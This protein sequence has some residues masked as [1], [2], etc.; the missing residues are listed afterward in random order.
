MTILSIGLG[1]MIGA[2]LRYFIS[3]KARGRLSTPFPIG[4]FIVNIIGS[5]VLGFLVALNLP[6]SL[7]LPFAEGFCGALTT[8]STFALEY[9]TLYSK[10]FHTLALIYIFISL[11]CGILFFTLGTLL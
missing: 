9:Y 11:V 10:G 1:G 8:F 6:A 7:W 2:M 5:F 3:Q 4:T